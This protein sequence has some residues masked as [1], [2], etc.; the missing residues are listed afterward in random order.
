MFN[1]TGYVLHISCNHL[2]YNT[3][4]VTGPASVY[5]G[6]VRTV[7]VECEAWMLALCLMAKFSK[8]DV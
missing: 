3:F 7:A 8:C 5:L 2:N 4:R 1:G 6:K